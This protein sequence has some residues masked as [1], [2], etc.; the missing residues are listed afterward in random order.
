MKIYN[1][2]LFYSIQKKILLCIIC[3]VVYRMSMSKH[4]LIAIASGS[5]KDFYSCN[6]PKLLTLQVL[7]QNKEYHKL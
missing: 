3:F 7:C 6:S 4:N 5:L 2:F 1:V